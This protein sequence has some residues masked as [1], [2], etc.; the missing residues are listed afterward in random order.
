MI[1]NKNENDNVNENIDEIV[2]VEENEEA[3]ENEIE[4]EYNVN[5]EED[6]D[7][8]EAEE[9]LENRFITIGQNQKQTVYVLR[10]FDPVMQKPRIRPIQKE[11]K[12]QMLDKTHFDVFTATDIMEGKITENKIK[13]FDTG[14][15]S[16]R[17]LYQE[18]K[19]GN[20]LVDIK[21]TGDG[22]ETLYIPTACNN[23]QL[24]KAIAKLKTQ[25]QAL[26][27]RHLNGE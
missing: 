26:Q 6:S 4:N 14:K 22:K 8:L 24:L 2:S 27:P 11:Y 10:G 5:P 17:L 25:L 1:P 12:G 9:A 13:W 16:G 20:Q 15:R 21:H 23:P 19:D 7:L 18:V 3:I